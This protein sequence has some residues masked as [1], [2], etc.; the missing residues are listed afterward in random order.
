S[1]TAV[2]LS[3]ISR[4][5]LVTAFLAAA[6]GG[7]EAMLATSLDLGAD[8]ALV[9]SIQ[10]LRFLVVLLMAPFIARR[11]SRSQPGAGAQT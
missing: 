7:L 1:G 8:A 5:P 11:L 9:L 2:L 3:R 4:I 6:P 10:L